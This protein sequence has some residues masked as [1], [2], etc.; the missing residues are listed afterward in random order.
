MSKHTNG[1]SYLETLTFIVPPECGGQIVEVAYASD[2]EH[3]LVIRRT[4]DQ[5]LDPSDPERMV[6]ASA[7]Y[8]DLIG[9]YE[10][11][12]QAPESDAGWSELVRR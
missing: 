5:S 7:E 11:W 9:D 2:S 1:T 3:E 12:N 6:Y 10:P 8:G 4:T